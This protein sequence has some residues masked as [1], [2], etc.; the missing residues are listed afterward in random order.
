MARI[1]KSN[2]N[3][4]VTGDR[5]FK[6]IQ[7]DMGRTPKLPEMKSDHMKTNAK[8]ERATVTAAEEVGA[9]Q[10]SATTSMTFPPG[11]KHANLF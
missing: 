3:L 5:F 7:I 9:S 1:N 4:Q 2:S 11:P 10:W 6:S 8:L